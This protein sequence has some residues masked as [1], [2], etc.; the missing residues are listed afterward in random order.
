MAA[1]SPKCN[2]RC[3]ALGGHCLV[4]SGVAVPSTADRVV[5]SLEGGGLKPRLMPGQ[6]KTHLT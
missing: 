2:P 6:R 5:E 4:V 1:L 3:A